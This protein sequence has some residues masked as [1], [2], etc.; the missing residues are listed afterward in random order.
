MRYLRYTKVN[1]LATRL[2]RRCIFLQT[3]KFTKEKEKGTNIQTLDT[4]IKAFK[5]KRRIEKSSRSK[6]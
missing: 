6:M 5:T 4:M 2:K 3:L 1:Y